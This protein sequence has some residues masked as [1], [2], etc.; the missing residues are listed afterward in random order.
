[1]PASPSTARSPSLM[2]R[3]KTSLQPA[4]VCWWLGH[5]L[6]VYYS[7]LYY[8]R[9]AFTLTSVPT[10]YYR[11]YLGVLSSYAIV[12]YKT[13]GKPQVNMQFL[14]RVAADEN[15]QYFFLALFWYMVTPLFVTLVP[16]FVFSAVHCLSYTNDPVLMTIFPQ[17]RRELHARHARSGDA[18]PQMSIPAQLSCLLST[19]SV[20]LGAPALHL[21]NICEV[22]AVMP[23]LVLA[24]LFGGGS[25]IAVFLYAHF[26]RLRYL[27]SPK[28]QATFHA[29]RVQMDQFFSS[30]NSRVPALVSKTYSK[31]RDMLI[32]FAERASA[33]AQPASS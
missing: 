17:V 9:L 15:M 23:C 8:T 14:Q 25:Y 2:D 22:V 29:F 6:V 32:A 19:T 21:A 11:A 33:Q 16:F 31:G 4:E 3:V 18:R 13:H 30:G 1:M 7:A 27:F 28:T 20:K 24:A 26:M 5:I 12:L 10:Y